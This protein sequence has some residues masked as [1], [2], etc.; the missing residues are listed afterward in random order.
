[1]KRL[2]VLPMLFSLSFGFA[3]WNVN[4]DYSVSGKVGIGTSSPGYRLDITN[5]AGAP[6]DLFRLRVDGAPTDFFTIKNQTVAGGQFIPAVYGFHDSDNRNALYVLGVAGDTND[7]GSEPIMVFDSRLLT[8]SAANRPLFAWDSYG[9][10]KMILSASGNLGLGVPDPTEK[11]SVNG[12]ISI[13]LAL[14][15]DN[16]SPGL[17]GASNDD[18]QYDGQYLNHYGYGFYL[19][20]DGNGYRGGNAY[21]SG[22]YGFEV[23]TGGTSRLRVNHNGD[24][25]IGTN[26]P[27]SKLH[28]SDG[29]GGDQLRFSRGTGTVR[30]AQDMNQD[31][32]YLFNHDASATY[33]F[34][35]AN[36]DV[37]IGT[38]TPDARLTVKGTIHSEEVRVDLSVPGPDYVFKDD[39][40]LLP[41][42]DLESYIKENSHL[43]EV[44]SA[45]EMEGNGLNLKEMNLILLKK[46][47]E[48]TLHII[49]INK[50]VETLEEQNTLQQSELERV[51]A[52]R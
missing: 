33:M 20:D 47:E 37:G 13:P 48:L 22:Y 25:G 49:E 9:N 26:G 39:Y 21:V 28:I 15:V 41:L 32:L 46:V 42:K 19:F 31:N 11:L 45:S 43:P 18:F 34:W 12:G 5:Q 24:V 23:F 3:Q 38:R 1:M 36:G 35:K 7:S 40:D 29:I 44:P 27:L 50:K 4:G 10:R 14:T 51:R 30:F 52:K 17:V 6:Q 8:A 16:D 2:V